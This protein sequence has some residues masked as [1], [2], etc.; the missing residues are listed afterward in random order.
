M[1]RSAA[2]SNKTTGVGSCLIFPRNLTTTPL[3]PIQFS[4]FFIFKIW[5][6]LS[7]HTS[8][9]ESWFSQTRRISLLCNHKITNKNCTFQNLFAVWFEYS[10]ALHHL[11]AIYFLLEYWKK[12]VI[13][14]KVNLLRISTLL[15]ENICA[16][17]TKALT[18]LLLAKQFMSSKI[19]FSKNIGCADPILCSFF[20][21]KCDVL[22]FCLNT[23]LPVD[24]KMCRT[25]ENLFQHWWEMAEM[26]NL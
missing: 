8:G 10:F 12:G 13:K 11:L 19:M 15:T 2:L 23:N 16:V 14:I 5:S 20:I 25:L 21:F 22:L 18:F 1:G 7:R 9:M 24:F 17:L 3:I 4:R 6:V 26:R